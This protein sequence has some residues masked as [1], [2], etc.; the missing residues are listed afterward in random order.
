M[1]LQ[2]ETKEI[3][4]LSSIRELPSLN[5]L[6]RSIYRKEDQKNFYILSCVKCNTVKILDWEGK[7]FKSKRKKASANHTC[8]LLDHSDKN[9]HTSLDNEAI[10]QI[11]QLLL[12]GI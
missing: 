8:S 1:S 9:Y 12:N 10:K 4:D 6:P 3:G 7:I 2:E 5:N 11:E